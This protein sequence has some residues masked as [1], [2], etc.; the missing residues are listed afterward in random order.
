MTDA[1]LV[2]VLSCA[3][4]LVGT[5]GGILA[6]QKLVNFRLQELEKKVEKHNNLVERMVEVE[7][8]AK[9]NTRR[10]EALEGKTDHLID[11]LVEVQS[12]E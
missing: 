2:A 9:G 3:G 12:N 7:Q 4:T 1:V 5:L 11:K 10:I 6:A 8:R